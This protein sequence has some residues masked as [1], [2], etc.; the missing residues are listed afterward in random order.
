MKRLRDMSAEEV[1]ADLALERHMEEEAQA[2]AKREA[3]DRFNAFWAHDGYSESVTCKICAENDNE[4]TF[5]DQDHISMEEHERWHEKQEARFNEMLK[6]M[7]HDRQEA[8]A[9]VILLKGIKTGGI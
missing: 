1:S 4:V 7:G 3:I 6:Y 9:E 5:S 2:Q 8:K